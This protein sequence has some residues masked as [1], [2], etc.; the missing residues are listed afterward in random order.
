MSSARE[1]PI[2]L[3]LLLLAAVLLLGTRLGAT[4][5]WAP[6][7]PRYGQVAEEVR[8]LEHGPAGLVLL[9]LGGEPYTQ[10]PPL[11]YWLA[12]LSGQIAGGRVTETA[13]RMPSVLAGI[14]TVLVTFALGRR[15]FPG[16]HAAF[17]SG[18]VLLT[19]F[20]FAHLARRAQ[21]DV[22]LTFFEVAAL[23]AF[24]RIDVAARAGAGAGATE[25]RET[26]R[27]VALLHL[28]L[29]AGALTK[30]PV[31]WIPLL[32]IVAYLAWERRL[33]LL[34][35]VVPAWAPLLSVAPVVVWIAGATQLAP[36]GFFSEA[37]IAN[38][39]E[40]FT[41]AASHVRPF[42]YYFYQLPADFLP[43]TL[44]LPAAAVVAVREFRRGG[45]PA[46]AWRLLT[47]W[48]LV[49]FL[50]FSA[51]SGK[52]GLYL[53]PAFPALALM[54][55]RALDRWS[56]KGELRIWA[57]RGFVVANVSVVSF[58]L[59]I[60][61]SGGIE[62]GVYPRFGISP[63]AALAFASAGAIGLVAGLVLAR[64]LGRPT[65]VFE[66]AVGSAL[67]LELVLFTIVYPGYDPEKSPRPVATLA[68]GLT[69]PGEAVGIFDD[70]GLAGGIL[71]YGNRP[72]EILP[73]PN[74]VSRFFDEGG[75]FVVLE[76][77]K[78]P[79]LEPVGEFT[80]HATTRREQR[81]LAVVSLND[82]PN[83]PAAPTS[84][85]SLH[86]EPPP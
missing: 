79:W 32:A 1:S 11:Y 72:V 40:R 6:D 48:V 13:A 60:A 56:S 65:G 50:I 22:L 47:V 45:E 17:L 8:A 67:A 80:V 43:W 52:R 30:G 16:T 84:T 59:A 7:E 78:L 68:A 5:F 55:G 14:F 4:D 57:V 62:A 49:P 86:P 27:T 9:H 21:L 39:F 2:P 31:A 36:S 28:A 10:K 18:A 82:N 66:A 41:Q 23:L 33:P 76:R 74:D 46:R 35:V 15:L 19:S 38:I 83:A 81:E 61:W 24:W 51:S 75:R 29:G 73:R 53:L 3:A 12:A 26:R 85:P 64:G 34:R 25:R 71:Y 37:V 54:L 42:Y 77:W 44:L 20:R 69:S 70:E 63:A 58:A